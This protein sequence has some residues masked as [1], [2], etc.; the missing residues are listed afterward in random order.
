MGSSSLDGEAFI[1]INEVQVGSAMTLP[2]G[3]QTSRDQ[4][5][6][7]QAG[8]RVALYV[9]NTTATP[10]TFRLNRFRVSYQ[11]VPINSQPLSADIIY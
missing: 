7:I 8:D 5:Y 11:I 9:R 6:K 3:S 2:Q 10:T 4:D 1:Y